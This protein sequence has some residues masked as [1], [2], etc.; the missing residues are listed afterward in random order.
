MVMGK[1]SREQTR[2]HTES[3]NL[4]HKDK[5][6][7]DDIEYVLAHWHPAANHNVG[8]I[9]AFFTPPDLASDFRIELHGDK[10]LDLCAGIGTLSYYARRWPY[11][12]D[13]APLVTCIEVN[14]YFVEIGKK[15]LPEINWICGNAFDLPEIIKTYNLGH[16]DTIMANPPFGKVSRGPDERDRL[17]RGKHMGG[18]RYKGPEFEYHLMDLAS[19]YAD[20][21]VFLVP[22]MSAP[23]RFSGARYFQW[24][25]SRACERFEAQTK[26]EA[27]AGCG[28][29]TNFFSDQWQMKAPATEILC[30]DFMEVRDA[31][32]PKLSNREV[33]HAS[34]AVYS[35]QADLF[36]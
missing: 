13:R 26:I 29:D 9:G 17:A 25:K 22:Q 1:L 3:E 14:P 5:L 21:G 24:Q 23:F 30:I 31:R 36:A 2:R 4:L 10:I 7:D 6:T 19:D 11:N 27:Q 34:G 16:F 28:I 18:P 35:E 8:T 20:Y 33:V 12:K 32:K 15:L